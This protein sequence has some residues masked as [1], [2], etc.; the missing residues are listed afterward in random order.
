MNKYLEKIAKE[1]LVEE[2]VA[3]PDIGGRLAG[4]LAGAVSAGLVTKKIAPLFTGAIS[5]RLLHSAPEESE[6]VL[7]SVMKDV[8]HRT[9]STAVLEEIGGSP[10]FQ[11]LL[12]A[13]TYRKGPF[14]LDMQSAET[15]RKYLDRAFRLKNTLNPIAKG[16]GLDV[17]PR[18]AGEILEGGP[19]KK[20]FIHYGGVP[21]TDVAFHEAG[22]ALDF[23]SNSKLKNRVAAIGRRSSTLSNVIGGAMLTDERTRDYAWAAPVVGALPTMREELMANIHGHRLIKQHGGSGKKFIGL[24]LANLAGYALAPTLSAATLA[25]INHLKRKGEEIDPDEYIKDSYE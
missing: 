14:Y 19:I 6:K 24:S 3:N 18:Y 16:L 11:N 1:Y 13:I 9:N 7:N 25:G 5:S 2:H 15:T 22:H 17:G 8:M 23:A 21:N 4:G 20:N 10:K 12:Q